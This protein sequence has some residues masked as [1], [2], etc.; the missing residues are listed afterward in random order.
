MP[1][2][3]RSSRDRHPVFGQGAGLVRAENRRR[4][5]GFNGGGAARQNAGARNSPGAHRHEYRQDNRK[6]FRQH[7][8]PESDAAEKR[9]EP[10]ASQGPVKQDCENGDP[11]AD[12]GEHSHKPGHLCLQTGGFGFQRAQRLA[13]LADLADGARRDHLCDPGTA[14]D[15]RSR[16]DVWRIFATGATASAGDRI[17]PD[18][19]SHGHGLA[20]QQR[21]VDL[22]VL[23]FDNRRICGNAIALGKHKEIS[24]R[25]L[26]PG[27]SLAFAVADNQRTRAGQ[28]PKGVQDALGPRFLHD[29]D[30]DRQIGKDQQDER[31]APVPK[32]QIDEASGDQQRQHWFA[33]NF[34]HNLERRAT[35]RSREFVVSLRL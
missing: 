11:A 14:H 16:K 23:A 15:Q 5:E 8:H 10:V 18:N 31:F 4:A 17:R 33:Q 26:A 32:R 27:Y 3:P 12:Q 7:R 34:E 24:A 20:G 6:L 25:H 28:V 9:V 19:F 35:L 13:D 21:F 30:C 2:A 29:G 1:S 22:Q